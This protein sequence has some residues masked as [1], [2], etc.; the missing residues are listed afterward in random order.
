MPPPPPCRLSGACSGPGS[1]KRSGYCGNGGSDSASPFDMGG[2]GALL[3]CMSR[4][5]IATSMRNLAGDAM[6]PPP[7]RPLT[8][9]IFEH[10][11]AQAALFAIETYFEE[12][13]IR[14]PVI[15]SGTIT[16]ASG[17]TLS[18]QT[19]EPFWDSGRHARPR[20]GG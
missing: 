11:N 14:L 16:D 20:P 2:T 15:V 17:R 8:E 5:C 6:G 12:H 18:G 13:A 7:Q 19:P 9:T 1:L 4:S 10:L 3:V